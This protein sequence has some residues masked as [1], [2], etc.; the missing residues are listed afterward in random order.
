MLA[1]LGTLRYPT[2]PKMGDPT[3]FSGMTAFISVIGII[4]LHFL[5][6]ATYLTELTKKCIMGWSSVKQVSRFWDKSVRSHPNA[7]Q[8]K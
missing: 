5:A 7:K 2:Q 1:S 4:F 3:R 8:L 6:P